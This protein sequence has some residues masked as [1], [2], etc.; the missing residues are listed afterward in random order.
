[1][2]LPEYPISGRP[3]LW[4]TN[5]RKMSA[6]NPAL[7]SWLYNPNSLWDDTTKIK[8]ETEKTEKLKDDPAEEL[9]D[10]IDSEMETDVK[11]DE[12]ETTTPKD[13]TTS[14]NDED[15]QDDDEE[16][17]DEEE[18]TTT[19]PHVN[20]SAPQVK[21]VKL[22]KTG[23]SP[24]PPKSQPKI[25]SNK[26]TPKVKPK[27]DGSLSIKQIKEM[28]QGKQGLFS[29]IKSGQ[30]LKK[31]KKKTNKK[32]L[33]PN[34]ANDLSKVKLKKVKTKAHKKKPNLNTFQSNLMKGL[35][36]TKSKLK[37]VED[38]SHL[39]K[40]IEEPKESQEAKKFIGLLQKKYGGHD[41][42]TVTPPSS[43]SEQDW[44]D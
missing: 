41:L 19:N 22:N 4:N 31:T 5:F 30:K 27:T 42:S 11:T 44:G 18:E 17:D 38:K 36:S 40:S 35:Q 7:Y 43:D 3:R 32:P 25:M 8:T 10:M 34:L 13:V 28:N 24:P 2:N 23:P 33:L 14:T 21:S 39:H 15:E 12:L 26:T 16:D 29:A 20:N 1:M 6:E 37:T 9:H